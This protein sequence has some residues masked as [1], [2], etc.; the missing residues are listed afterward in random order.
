M[1]VKCVFPLICENKLAFPFLQFTLIYNLHA[2][3]F[4][5]CVHIRA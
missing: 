2:Y 1:Y 5:N 4:N 3:G